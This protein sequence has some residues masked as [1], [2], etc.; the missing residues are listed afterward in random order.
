M[1]MREL[2]FL[3]LNQSNYGKTCPLKINCLPAC[4]PVSQS[5][6]LLNAFVIQ[7]CTGNVPR[8]FYFILLTGLEGCKYLVLIG[9]LWPWRPF[10]FG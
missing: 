1:C 3:L 7:P 6:T 9:I 10:E 8:G 5:V 2:G 4:L